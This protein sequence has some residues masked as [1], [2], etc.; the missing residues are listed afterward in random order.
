MG[1]FHF[2]P[3]AFDEAR[4]H[5]LRVRHIVAAPHRALFLVVEQVRESKPL[6]SHVWKENSV[7]W[8]FGHELSEIVEANARVPMTIGFGGAP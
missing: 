5:G 2:E 6:S 3:A 1:F 7:R 4:A 8:M